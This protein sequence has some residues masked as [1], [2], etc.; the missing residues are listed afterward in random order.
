MAIDS[1]FEKQE[2]LK[3]AASATVDLIKYKYDPIVYASEPKQSL[4][5]Q[6]SYS[7]S[8]KY[9]REKSCVTATLTDFI[10]KYSNEDEKGLHILPEA[11]NNS[12]RINYKLSDHRV[13]EGVHIEYKTSYD[14]DGFFTLV[15]QEDLVKCVNSSG[16]MMKYENTSYPIHKKG[17]N[18]IL[19]DTNETEFVD[20]SISKIAE[21]DGSHR[22]EIFAV[23][24]TTESNTK[25]VLSQIDFKKA[26]IDAYAFANSFPCIEKNNCEFSSEHRA[27]KC[28]RPLYP[29]QITMKHHSY[30]YNSDHFRCIL[31]FFGQ[32]LAESVSKSKN[33][34]LYFWIRAIG[35]K[36]KLITTK[37]D[38]I[39]ELLDDLLKPLNSKYIYSSRGPKS[40]IDVSL[41]FIPVCTAEKEKV[42]IY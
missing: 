18:K 40:F 41:K 2:L 8:S 27:L 42:N 24:G 36:F 35:T 37:K 30:E 3:R 9:G 39:P 7:S 10:D 19:K 16:R 5:Q 29:S 38:N 22:I 15:H 4:K 20:M 31:S 23:L 26:L 34:K 6:N 14:I 33:L 28:S 11:Y 21:L 13:Q 1:E 12:T 17:V 25:E 32:H